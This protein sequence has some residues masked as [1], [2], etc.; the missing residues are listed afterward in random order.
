MIG[1]V[2]AAWCTM[3]SGRPFAAPGNWPNRR[4]LPPAAINPGDGDAGWPYWRLLMH[5]NTLPLCLGLCP[6]DLRSI[7][8]SPGCRLASRKSTVTSLSLR[9]FRPSLLAAGYGDLLRGVATDG[10]TD[11]SLQLGR[12]GLCCRAIY[13]RGAGCGLH[14]ESD[15]RDRPRLPRG[16]VHHVHPPRVLGHFVLDYR[17]IPIRSSSATMNT[18]GQIGSIFSPPLV[19]WLLARGATGMPRFSPLG[20]FSFWGGVLVPCGS[21]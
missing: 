12:T 2:W 11:G 3:V 8:A 9:I 6:N 4:S 10:A 18:A 19:T 21:A 1:V 13:S 20:L 5:R 14:G 16:D 17:R 15:R 7:S